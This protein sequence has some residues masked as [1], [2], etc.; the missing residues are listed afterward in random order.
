MHFGD[1]KLSLRMQQVRLAFRT[2]WIKLLKQTS[3]YFLGG[4]KKKAFEIVLLK[5][6]SQLSQVF[7][8]RG[9]QRAEMGLERPRTVSS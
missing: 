6:Y 2:D 8:M 5:P 9:G 7:R 3:K 4:K 1:S